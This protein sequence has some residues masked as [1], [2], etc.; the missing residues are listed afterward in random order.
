VIQRRHLGLAAIL[1]L[2]LAARVVGLGYGL[3]WLFYFHDEPQ[4]VLRALRLGTGDLNPHFFGWPGILMFY[5][6]LASFIGLFVYGRLTGLWRNAGGFANAY[7]EDPTA[8]YVLARLQSVLSGVWTVYIAHGLGSTAYSQAVGTGAALAM[9][10]SALHAHYSHLAHPVI[11]L[12]A[13]A[14]LGLWACVRLA[15]DGGKHEFRIFAVALGLGSL[16]QY[17][18]ALLAVPLGIAMLLRIAAEPRR[19]WH[20]I[21]AAALAGFAGLAIHLILSPFTVLDYK[22]FLHDLSYEAVKASGGSSGPRAPARAIL[23]FITDALVPSL[24][25]PMLVL[26]GFGALAAFIRRKPADLVLLSFVGIYFLVMARSGNVNDRYGLPLVLPALL[27]AARLVE[28]VV[29][30]LPAAWRRTWYT[31]V[32]ML[33]LSWSSVATLIEQDYTMTQGD[34]RIESLRWFEA[35]VPF[36]DRVVIDMH[37]YRNT[38]SPPLNENTVRLQER[39]EEVTKGV[40]GSGNSRA[41]EP[42]FR[43]RLEHPRK[44]AYYLMSTDMG[45][46]ARRVDEYVGRGFRWAVVSM[47]AREL[48]ER[49]ATGGDSTHVRYYLDLDRQAKLVAEF[50]PRRWHALGPVIRVYRLPEAR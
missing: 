15:V 47:E 48:H 13:F 25:L 45:Y 4:V 32:V 31:P 21:G 24:S 46:D 34:T 37:R 26:S 10:V 23:A 22:Q 18:A 1:L 7:F 8:F 44:N 17:H 5:V 6:A 49:I 40:E 12:T 30:R 16:A 11:V 29:F 3:P 43:Y 20:W 36:D 27:F 41:Y 14:A 38:A 50:K 35:N 33:A 39:I 2:A 42:F 9:A 19:V 28:E